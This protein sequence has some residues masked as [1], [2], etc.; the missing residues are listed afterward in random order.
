MQEPTHSPQRRRER[1]VAQS[2]Y[3]GANFSAS[4]CVLGDSAVVSLS[5]Q[6]GDEAKAPADALAPSRLTHLVGCAASRAVIAMRKVFARHF[7][8]LDLKV[9]E[10][11]ILMRVA[12]NAEVNQKQIGPTLDIFRRRTWPPRWTAWSGAAGLNGCAARGIGARC[13]ST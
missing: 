10:F 11:S 12:A 4:L 2:E 3:K 1:R 13:T 7:G 5:S 6:A 9:V 8:P